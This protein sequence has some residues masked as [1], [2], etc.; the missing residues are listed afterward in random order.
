MSYIHLYTY[1]K[2]LLHVTNEAPDRTSPIG[3]IIDTYLKGKTTTSDHSIHLLF[4]A[5]RWELASTITAHITAG[6]TVIA[7]RYIHS[8]MI[9]SAAKQNPAL[10]LAW[11][12]TPDIGLPKPDVVVFLDLEPE[13]ARERGGFGEEVY[14]KEEMQRRVRELFLRVK[15]DEGEGIRDVDAGSSLEVVEERVWGC[16]ERVLKGVEAGE[17]GETLEV[18]QE[19]R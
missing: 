12:R 6:T 2:G 7:D 10:T 14:E 4:S 8:G 5:N 18:V 17:S 13:K 9:Y 11:A 19:L 16:V 15:G 3:Q 1:T